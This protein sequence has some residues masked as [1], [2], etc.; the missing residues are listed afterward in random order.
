MCQPMKTAK[1]LTRLGGFPS[2]SESGHTDNKLVSFTGLQ[3]K[4]YRSLY[5]AGF[6]WQMDMYLHD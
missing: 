4:Q 6:I 1:T 2:R 5:A 3:L